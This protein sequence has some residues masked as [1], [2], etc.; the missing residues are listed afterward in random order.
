MN[1]KIFIGF[2]KRLI[3]SSKRKVYHIVDNL[4]V[5]H[6]KPVN[7]WVADRSDEIELYYLTS[8]SPDLNTDE[9]LNCDLKQ[10]MSQ[11]PV[12]GTREKLTQNVI[13]HMRLLQKRPDR[14]EKYFNHTSLKYAA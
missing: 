14:V 8:Y 9:Y 2:L 6:N 12:P 10:D 3:K 13:S 11:R 4:R 7:N 1:S 5:L